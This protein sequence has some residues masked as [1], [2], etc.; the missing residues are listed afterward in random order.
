MR[1]QHGIADG[2][3]LVD[4]VIFDVHENLPV[5]GILPAGEVLHWNK[6][7]IRSKSSGRQESP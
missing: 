3:S 7:K 6:L 5:P 1:E 2:L 4:L